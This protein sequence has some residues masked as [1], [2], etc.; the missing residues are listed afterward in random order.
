MSSRTVLTIACL[1]IVA[2]LLC[3][4]TEAQTFC[5]TPTAV[6]QPPPPDSPQPVCQP[7]KCDRC[8]KSPCYVASGVY[9]T[10]ALDLALPTTGTYNLIAQRL[11][12]SSRPV[13]GPAGVG[14]FF[15]I[16][17]RV[18]YVTYLV[19]APS[20]YS[21]EV[22][23]FMPDGIVYR[24]S[25]DAAGA[26][27]APPGRYD[28][29]VRN[30][31]STYSLTL[32][33]TR[34]VFAFNADGA[35]ASLTDGF[36]NVI[37]WTYDSGG[38]VQRVADSAGSGRY[39]DLTWGPD[40]RVSALTDNSGRQ[41]KYYYDS[42]DGTLTGVADPT[43]SGNASLRSTNYTYG[44]GRFGKVLTQISDRWNRVISELEWYSDG[45]LKSYTDGAYDG[46]PTSVG[47][48]Y[49]YIYNPVTATTT[50]SDS[51]AS[52]SYQYGDTGLVTPLN[53]VNGQPIAVTS[54]AGGNFQYE[55]DAVGH[56]TK[57]SAT[58]PD[59]PNGSGTVVWWF[60]YDTAWPDQVAS[61][62]P[63][64]ASGNLKTNWAG[65]FYDYYPAGSVSPSALARVW[66]VRSDTFTRDLFASYNY[67]SHGRI[68]GATD[69]NGIVTA[70]GYNAAGDLASITTSGAP[71]VTQIT[72]D[73]VGR[74]LT[75]TDPNGHVT[76]TT[77][78]ALDRV[79]SVTL[80]KPSAISAYE[81][82]TASSYDNY[83][84]TTG[85]DIHECYRPKRARGE[86]WI[87]RAR[88]SCP[89]G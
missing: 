70:Y 9:S 45:K 64:D 5:L 1:V 28:K 74:P 86:V 38:R 31:D 27:S 36:G 8:T 87:R 68:S 26:F 59:P 52:T 85:P 33:H 34:T 35:V 53:Y 44:A 66:R 14:W 54:P 67:T 22:D 50:K 56:V 23:A 30:S 13:D 72:Y 62:I 80:P 19:A 79:L 69:D 82:V 77:Y 21:H 57:I 81:T 18:Y 43:V 37:T 4:Q 73:A 49:T 75:V 71:N 10:D 65:W 17:P 61:I 12:D 55:Y 16:M 42:S 20:T 83:D 6:P 76:T 58:S 88:A 3:V 32:Q 11:Y 15:S 24:F 39:I 41:V 84:S 46:S 48:K 60:T 2:S 29:L 89:N 47:E 63:K 25:V 7:R 78:D 40:G 51:I